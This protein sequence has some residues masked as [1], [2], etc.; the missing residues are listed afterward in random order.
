MSESDARRR[1][2]SVTLGTVQP[3]GSLCT[4]ETLSLQRLSPNIYYGVDPKVELPDEFPSVKPLD[5]GHSAE[6][7]K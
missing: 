7:L 4:S 5:A 3:H 2:F 1:V 6:Y